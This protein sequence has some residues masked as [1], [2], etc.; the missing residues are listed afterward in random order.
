MG[1]EC[2]VG[3]TCDRVFR[4]YPEN[5]TFAFGSAELAVDCLWRIFADGKPAVT[6]RDHGRK[7]G[8]PQPVDALVEAQA[9]L[10]GRPVLA[11]HVREN[12]A[13]LQIEFE[14]NV[15]LRSLGT[16]LATSRGTWM[17]RVCIWS[18]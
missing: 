5:S 3:K 7:Y 6:S 11:V 2:L 9:R 16:R 15:Q 12:S 18:R 14:G 4:H 8:L 1:L 13:D 10:C 17:H